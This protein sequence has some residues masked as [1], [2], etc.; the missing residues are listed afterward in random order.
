[1]SRHRAGADWVEISLEDLRRSVSAAERDLEVGYELLEEAKLD[2]AERDKLDLQE[3]ITRSQRKPIEGPLK[4]FYLTIGAGYRPVYTRLGAKYPSDHHGHP[5]YP[6]KLTGKGFVVIEAP[7]YDWACALTWTHL[8][9][10]FSSVYSHD[11]RDRAFPDWYPLGEI[12]RMDTYGE[13]T[14]K[15]P[16]W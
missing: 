6:D 11:P 7:D 4:E 15:E 10:K 1:M 8:G 12:G 9:A 14:W 13:I 16:E 5:V 2:L 3:R